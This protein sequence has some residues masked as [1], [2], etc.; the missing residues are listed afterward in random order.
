MN[1]IKN[2]VILAAA[3]AACCGPAFAADSAG[4]GPMVHKRGG[5]CTGL[6]LERTEGAKTT[7]TEIQDGVEVLIRST[8]P[9]IAAKLQSEA[10]AYYT[11]KKDTNCSCCAAALTGAATVVE[12]IDDGVKI[13]ITGKTPELAKKIKVT[14]GVIPPPVKVKKTAPKKTVKKTVSWLIPLGDYGSG[15]PGVY[16][17][18]A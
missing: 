4:K 12:N 2:I 15:Q 16:P 11:A 10:P 18:V 7:A 1:G 6:W 17:S 3:L 5:M 14:A 8:D 13:T 9:V